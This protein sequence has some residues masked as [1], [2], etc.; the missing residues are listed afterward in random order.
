MVSDVQQSMQSRESSPM[1]ETRWSLR[2]SEA[3]PSSS[4]SVQSF[5]QRSQSRPSW[6]S[7]MIPSLAMADDPKVPRELWTCSRSGAL[8]SERLVPNSRNRPRHAE[9]LAPNAPKRRSTFRLGQLSQLGL[10]LFASCAKVLQHVCGD[11]LTLCRQCQ[12]D[13]TG[14]HA[15]F[16]LRAT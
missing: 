2:R 8:D 9:R 10:D 13:V 4:T 14:F 15:R 16:P 1:S 11:T 3:N 6:P 7:I 5:R 12:Q